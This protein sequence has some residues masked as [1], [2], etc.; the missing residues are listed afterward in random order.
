MSEM[1]AAV[2]ASFNAAKQN[3][4]PSFPSEASHRRP[5]SRDV[6][7]RYLNGASS[8]SSSSV[9]HKSSSPSSAAKRCQSP[10]VTRPVT[11]SVTI[12]R[13][14]STPRRDSLDRRGSGSGSG[15]EVSSAQ[16][17]LLTS[18]RSLFASFQADSF[19][20]I[21]F[22]SKL[23]SS[24]GRGTVEKKKK[25]IPT[26]IA[27]RSCGAQQE[28]TKLNEQ[29]PRSVQP[30]C[31]SRS[32]DF[33]DTRKKLNGS[34]N[35]VS[36]ALQNS[37]VN[38]NNRPRITRDSLSVGLETESVSSGSSNGRGRML[39]A[40]GNVVQGR[41]P[42][43]AS[44]LSQHRLEPGSQVSKSNGL[45]KVSVDSHVLSPKGSQLFP[46]S[47]QIRPASPSKFGMTAASPRGTSIARGISPSRG[48]VPPRGISPSG[49]M[50]PLRVRSSLT[51]TTPLVLNFAVDA[52]EKIRDNGVADA[53][54]LKLL[55]N[56]LLQWRFANARA[57]AVISSQKMRAE[58]RLYNAWINISMLY[59]SVRAKR[60]ELQHLKQNLKLISIL[61]RQM[62][63]LEEWLVM[64][65]D[66]MGSLVGAAEAL[67]GSTL[68]LPVDCGAMV[69]V[70]SVK[71]AICSAVDVMQAMASSICLLL[72]KV[73]K[74]SSLAAELGSVSVKEERML[75]VCRDLLNTIS[76]LQ[77]T[78]C[79]LKTQIT[80]LK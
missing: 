43:L 48:V 71:D 30:S 33:T 2:S 34:G 15:G 47:E 55:H 64:E 63:H 58:K 79:S 12:N 3:K 25:T 51:K 24:P 1:T 14:R 45:R 61:N 54:L 31:L 27:S 46:K 26:A 73:G 11:P 70:Q 5:K 68:C 17:M 65:R 6:A 56:R 22:R 40:R 39:P 52:K 37:M 42:Q 78:E 41:V 16:R 66:Y 80:Q 36:R 57:N 50:S 32:V 4:P 18:G 35:G 9:F 59:D 8:F 74:I 28:K 75:D 49:R 29:W 19:S 23:N 20:G 67:K 7:S 44:N 72:P 60:I 38:N 21:E 10:I 69:N 77:V 76:A 53:H 62:G 13:P